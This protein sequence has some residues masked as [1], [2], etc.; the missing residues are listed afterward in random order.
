[1]SCQPPS[2]RAAGRRA[3]QAAA[4][5]VTRVSHRVGFYQTDGMGVMHHANYLHLLE[6]SR[7]AWL[8]EHDRPYREYV[9]Q[10]LHFAVTRAEL[11]YRQP[12]R[13]DDELTVAVEL[14]W[15]RGASLAMR[16]QVHCGSTLIATAQTE[17]ALVGP[18]GRPTRIPPE[19][20]ARWAALSS[21][22]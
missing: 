22:E 3:Q 7:V 12:A 21:G 19:L 1:V 8:Q 4:V 9:A 14:A 2:P 13:F 16:Y 5:A 20:R 17:H 10:G 6:T 15:V 11:Q 18:G